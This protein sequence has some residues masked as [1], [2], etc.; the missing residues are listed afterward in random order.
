[1]I[2]HV[3]IPLILVIICFQST[4]AFQAC[5]LLQTHRFFGGSLSSGS[6]KSSTSRSF[7]IY[8][9]KQKNSDS[10]DVHHHS[11]APPSKPPNDSEQLL[12]EVLELTQ[13]FEEVQATIRA[14]AEIYKENAKV[15]ESEISRLKE[16]STELRETVSE[17][18]KTIEELENAIEN[19][20]QASESM[21]EMI[22]QL[23]SDELLDKEKL[24]NKDVKLSN[25]E[26]GVKQYQEKIRNLEHQVSCLQDEIRTKNGSMADLE[27]EMYT[28]SQEKRSI[29]EKEVHTFKQLELTKAQFRDKLKDLEA[30]KLNLT[31]TIN[32]TESK[33]IPLEKEREQLRNELR[34]ISNTNNSKGKIFETQL[35]NAKHEF[36]KELNA[37]KQSTKETKF[38]LE[39]KEEEISNLEALL[40]R[41][42][43]QYEKTTELWEKEK[44]ELLEKK[45]QLTKDLTAA[46]EEI[47]LIKLSTREQITKELIAERTNNAKWRDEITSQA[48]AGLIERDAT[49]ELM[50]DKIEQYEQERTSLRK[51]TKLGFMKVRTYIGFRKYLTF[52]RKSKSL[53][54]NDDNTDEGQQ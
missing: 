13:S 4:N 36:S 23:S 9:N 14:N 51:L 6:N 53:S 26:K 32:A 44:V 18:D 15:L 37:A 50:S 10:M 17:K 27:K 16:E 19:L 33:L 5:S 49:I 25:L 40:S 1:M 28:M 30:E 38:G 21:E 47:E 11:P 39:K 8:A 42:K 48:K 41:T 45:E 29:H 43:S 46:H 34:S 24:E 7:L 31:L 22:E 12:A 2:H 20:E 52:L 54:V 35:E 3:T